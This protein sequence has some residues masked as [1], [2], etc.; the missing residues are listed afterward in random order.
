MVNGTMYKRGSVLA[1]RQKKPAHMD[2]Q[3][4]SLIPRVAIDL[5][6]PAMMLGF[7][8]YSSVMFVV[9]VPAAFY[10]YYN[11]FYQ[12]FLHLYLIA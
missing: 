5:H 3:A 10:N 1:I 9:G 11:L 7:L 12:S 6:L 4:H 2:S 8:V